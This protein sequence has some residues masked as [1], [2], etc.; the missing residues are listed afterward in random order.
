MTNYQRGADVER[1]VRAYLESEGWY[2]I[3]SAGSKG[4]VDLLAG[5]AGIT[6]ALQVKRMAWPGPLERSV[7]ADIGVRTGWQPWAVR[8]QPRQPL[9]WAWINDRAQLYERTLTRLGDNEIRK[10]GHRE[11]SQVQD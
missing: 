7:L 5:L 3:R 2:V 6:L 4:A 11:E 8:W 1:S 10:S 9:R